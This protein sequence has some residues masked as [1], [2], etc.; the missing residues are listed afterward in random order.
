MNADTTWSAPAPHTSHFTRIVQD[1]RREGAMSVT[2]AGMHYTAH[3]YGL[4]YSGALDWAAGGTVQ[5]LVL[6]Y[7]CTFDI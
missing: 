7:N 6:L 2:C 1:T 5:S 3:C 4:V